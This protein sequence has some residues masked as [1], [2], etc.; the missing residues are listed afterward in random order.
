[1]AQADFNADASGVTVTGWASTSISPYIGLNGDVAVAGF[2]DG[3]PQNW[4]VTLDG[5][6]SVSGVELSADAHARLDQT[7]LL[8]KGA[9]V[10]PLTSVAMSGNISKNGVD[11]EGTTTVTIPIVGG[12]QILQEV[13]DAA[14]CGYETVTDAAVCG[15]QTV[16]DGAVCGYTAVT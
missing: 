11:L 6:L 8:V 2:F 9:F 16:A 7:G 13:T 15:S 10:T 12:K 1:M 3:N 14:V 4:Y 5:K